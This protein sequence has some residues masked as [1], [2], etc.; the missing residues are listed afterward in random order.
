MQETTN[1]RL[2]GIDIDLQRLL[3]TFLRKWWLI[4]LCMIVGASAAYVIT[5][6]CVTPVYQARISIY[7][8]NNKDSENKE[9]LSSADLT[10][11]QRL[12]NTYV[13]ISKSDRVLEK[14]SEKLDGVYSARW[15]NNAITA[16]Q[17]NGTEIFCIYVY[18]TDPV[19]A[20]RIANVVAEVAPV[21]ISQIIEGTSAQVVDTAKVPTSH[22][23]PNYRRMTLLGAAVGVF[24]ALVF[25]TLHHLSDTHIKSENDLINLYPLPVLG[26]IPDFDISSSEK[27]YGYSTTKSEEGADK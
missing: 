9:Y 17:L 26:R 22:Y 11:S 4:L 19:E 20:A 18:H 14:V 24:V 2:G 13:S 10:A 5:H 15:L 23:S 3:H 6:R 27:S 12:V 7:V 25:L 21:E 1:E 16:S 8:N